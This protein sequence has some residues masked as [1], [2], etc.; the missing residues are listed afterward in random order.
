[1]KV[2]ATAQVVEK[3]SPVRSVS[4]R[5]E[6]GSRVITDIQLRTVDLQFGAA[7]GQSTGQ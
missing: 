6:N 5:D 1:M 3:R 2:D 4:T 7:Q